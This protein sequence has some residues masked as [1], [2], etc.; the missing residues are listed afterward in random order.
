MHASTLLGFCVLSVIVTD[1]GLPCSQAPSLLSS[2]EDV[3][4]TWVLACLIY[5]EAQYILEWVAWHRL[6][7]ADHFYLYDHRSTDRLIDVLKPLMDEGLVTLISV[8]K[9]V[10]SGT[11][12]T[13]SGASNF[14]RRDLP[15][16]IRDAQWASHWDI[17]EFLYLGSRYTSFKELL[18]KKIFASAGGIKLSRKSA[19]TS[20]RELRLKPGE[21]ASMTF[22]DLETD[23][24]V[25]RSD[26]GKITVN[27]GG[28]ISG[29]L[30]AHK[31]TASRGR[32]VNVDGV[33]SRV[34]QASGDYLGLDVPFTSREPF[35]IHHITRSYEDCKW[36]D[37]WSSDR[38]GTWRHK[39]PISICE[40]RNS[41]TKHYVA[42]DYM[43]IPNHVTQGVLSL[44]PR[45]CEEMH[46]LNSA[47]CER[48]Q[49][50]RPS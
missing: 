16:R 23:K 34:Q 1:W 30:L 2:R 26:P 13:F 15:S 20:G 28:S 41:S 37:N 31:L 39:M 29:V 47:Y 19:G 9:T 6:L 49:C 17:D 45:L 4:Y 46:R 3:R 21:L 44:R 36:K 25:Q 22:L 50:C 24:A 38:Q 32:L 42:S 12:T 48:V 33:P 35:L 43:P 8:P 40:K 18:R 7:G 10:P 14:F 11:P 5:N 27:V